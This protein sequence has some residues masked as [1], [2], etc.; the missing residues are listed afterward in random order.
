MASLHSLHSSSASVVSPVGV[1]VM[2][3]AQRRGLAAAVNK[4]AVKRM[5]MDKVRITVCGGKGGNGCV[6]YDILSPGKKRPS[7]GNGGKV[8]SV[9]AYMLIV[10][11]L[12]YL[13]T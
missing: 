12:I 8:C 9:L 5:F 6:S 1:V 4:N 3:M 10:R 2:M 7:G 13:Y 11:L